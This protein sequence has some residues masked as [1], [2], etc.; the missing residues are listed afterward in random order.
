MVFTIIFSVLNPNVFAKEKY[1][2]KGT[3]QEFDFELVQKDDSVVI[4]KGTH[5]SGDE[6]YATLNK[7]TDEITMEA[8]EKPKGLLQRGGDKITKYIVKANTID[9]TLNEVDVTVIDA[10]T[11]HQFHISPDHVQ[12]Q[13][14]V[15]VPLVTWGG[16]ALL[17]Y[18]LEHAAALTIAGITAYAASE[19]VKD[20][21]K[22][23]K[24]YWPAWIRNDDVYIGQ[25]AFNTDAEAF[26]WLK[27]S[28]SGEVNVFARTEAKAQ[29]AAKKTAGT[30]IGH[31]AHGDA[32]YYKHYHPAKPLVTHPWVGDPYKN[33]CW[34]PF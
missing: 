33:H 11:N 16:R 34:Y 29:E 5:N 22:S 20:I 28:N 3:N 12:A 10:E 14:P 13:L 26:A 17:V 32:G 6:L 7:V 31:G 30:Y 2:D 9:P 15:L 19:L 18:L 27:T 23:N 1:K 4:V 8:V 25:D 24:N 21:K